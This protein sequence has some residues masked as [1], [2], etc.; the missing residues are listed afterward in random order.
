MNTPEKI[1]SRLSELQ[2]K[3]LGYKNTPSYRGKKIKKIRKTTG[4]KLPSGKK[5]TTIE[6]IF[7]K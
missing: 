1:A 2:K 5:Y 4:Q 6:V 3:I 7:E